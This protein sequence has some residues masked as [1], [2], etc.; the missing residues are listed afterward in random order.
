MIRDT[1]PAKVSA[2]AAMAFLTACTPRVELAAPQEPIT[3]NLNVKI[4]HEVRV[5]VEKDLEDILSKE[6]GLF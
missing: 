3:I 6:S 2:V 5:K 1:F 4:D